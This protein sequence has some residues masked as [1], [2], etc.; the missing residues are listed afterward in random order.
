MVLEST[1]LA[2]DFSVYIDFAPHWRVHGADSDLFHNFAKRPLA[3]HAFLLLE[4][5]GRG[6]GTT[7]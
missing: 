3:E 2:A 1:V 4:T 7:V 5:L 6:C